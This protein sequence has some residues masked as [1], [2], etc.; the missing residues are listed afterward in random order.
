MWL[1]GPIVLIQ[2][3]ENDGPIHLHCPW[4]EPISET[5]RIIESLCTDPEGIVGFNLAFDWFHIC[6]LYTVLDLFKDKEVYPIDHIKEYVELEPLGSDGLCLK[7]VKACD[8]MLHARKGPYQST[9]NRDDIRIKRVPTPLAQPLANELEK[10]VSL[11]PIY[12]ARRKDKTKKQWQVYDIRDEDDEIVPDFKDVVLKFNPST[13]LKALAGDALGVSDIILFSDVELDSRF[14]PKEI[15]YAPFA[16]ASEQSK[17]NGHAWPLVIKEHITHWGYN[18]HARKYASDDVKYTR[19]LYKYFGSPKLGDNDS[20]LACMV[21]ACRW[22]GYKIDLEG[23]ERLKKATSNKNIKILP[24]GTKFEIPTSPDKARIYIQ[25]FMSEEERLV[26]IAGRD[27]EVSTKKVNLEAV[28]KWKNEDGT[29]HPSASRAR[30]VLEARQSN[31][32]V[33]MFEKFLL[34]KRF[35]AS[36]DVIGA[37]S[38]RMSGGDDLNAQGIEKEGEVRQQFPLAWDGFTL[39]GGDFSA[40]EVTLAEAAFGDDDLR[41][42]LLK[43]KKIHALFGVHVFPHMTYEQILATDGTHDDIY[44]RC[45]SAVFAMFYG[46]EGFTLKDRLGVDIEIA[47]RAYAAFCRKYKKVGESRKKVEE[48]F[49]SMRQKGGIGTKIEW[50]EPKD[51]ME[52][53]FGFRRYF[54][55]E[56]QICKALFTLANNPPKEWL[57]LKLRV[58]RRADRIQTM[59]GA[60][61][62]ALYA[63]AFAQQAAN[64]RAANNHLIQSSGAEITKAVQRKIWDIQPSGINNWIVQPMNIHDEIMCPVA[65]GYEEKVK[66]IVNDTVESF[67]PKVPLI[68]MDWKIGLKSWGDKNG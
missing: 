67:R 38:S 11:K 36:F 53:M 4:T 3:A 64:M 33:N 19:D 41:A 65:Y 8:L 15:G 45:K 17:D 18:E 46:G 2:W 1:Y 30:E 39:C 66:K 54:T 28:K 44:K 25:E 42:D 52:S 37:K 60:T 61:Q 21:A 43:G 13:A 20:E 55:L 47:D 24:D 31:Y 26:S 50:H 68:K 14:Y 57:K 63:A 49:C 16:K 9:M 27:L 6:Q 48:A 23:L 40:F 51:Y 32:K 29:E 35:F 58:Q 59:G 7:P 56:N 12:F 62:S 22:R 5:L 34:A 10:R